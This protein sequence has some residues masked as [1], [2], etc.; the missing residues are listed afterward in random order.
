MLFFKHVVTNP[1]IQFYFSIRVPSLT[2]VQDH[3]QAGIV[4]KETTIREPMT[5]KLGTPNTHLA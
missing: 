5:P 2:K 4:S 3:S 1:D